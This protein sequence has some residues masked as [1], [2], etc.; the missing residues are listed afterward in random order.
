MTTEAPAGAGAHFAAIRKNWL[1]ISV[2]SLLAVIFLA[3]AAAA[4]SGAFLGPDQWAQYDLANSIGGRFYQLHTW[5]TYWYRSLYSTSFPFGWPVLIFLADH[6]IGAGPRTSVLLSSAFV[7][8]T[9]TLAELFGRRRFSV[10]WCGLALGALVSTCLTAIV[11][12]AGGGTETATCAAMLACAFLFTRP[13]GISVRSGL[14]MGTISGLGV[15][16]RFD[17][18]PQTAILFLLMFVV[19]G[20]RP[21]LAFLVGAAALVSPWI[22]YSLTHF[23]TPFVSDA[24]LTLLSTDRTLAVADWR[25]HGYPSAFTFPAAW[26]LKLAHGV[27]VMIKLVLDFLITSPTFTLLILGAAYVAWRKRSTFSGYLSRARALDATLLSDTAFRAVLFSAIFLA[28][29]PVLMALNAPQPRYLLPA[30]TYFSV[31]AVVLIAQS[32]DQ[33]VRARFGRRLLPEAALLIAVTALLAAPLVLWRSSLKAHPAAMASSDFAPV[34]SCLGDQPSG[35]TMIPG[36]GVLAA[37]F[38]A[39][40]GRI[41]AIEP[42]NL[43]DGSTRGRLDSPAVASFRQLIGARYVLVTEPADLPRLAN[44]G[45]NLTHVANCRAGL[46]EIR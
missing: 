37:E 39:L 10:R 30:F 5:R 36:D 24:G 46:Y 25:P 42:T 6:A 31:L 17:W 20:W 2:G 41:G 27:L 3:I 12:M 13:A 29:V 11:T 33:L 32:V 43:A 4:W 8:L 34:L 23:G 1:A 35:S 18:E 15:M 28:Q 7:I 21:A 14:L 44:Y 26:A 19:A 22:A 45:W 16:M 40:T 38:G 9:C